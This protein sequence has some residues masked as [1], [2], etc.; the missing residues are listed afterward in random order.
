M[1]D[2]PDQRY[3][4]VRFGRFTVDLN[5]GELQEGERRVAIQGKPLELLIALLERPG[6]LVTREALYARLWPGVTGDYQHGL[7]TAVKKLRRALGDPAERPVYIETLARRGY[8][9]LTP[10]FDLLSAA[11]AVTGSEENAFFPEPG[12]RRADSEAGRLYLQGY[13]CWNKRTPASQNQALAFFLHARELDPANSDYNAAI[14]L[15]HVMRAWHGVERPV[16]AVAEAKSAAVVALLHDRSQVLAC[17]VLAW[18]RGAF[19][20]DL[21]GA[22]S[23]LRTGI[24][25]APDQSWGY[26]QLAIFALA[27]GASEEADE[28]LRKAHE[29][30]PVSPTIFAVRGFV[31]CMSG[32]FEEA[33]E[34]GR[35]AV[36]RDPEFGLAHLYY[37]LELVALLRFDEAARHLAL[38]GQLMGESAEVRAALGMAIALGGDRARAAHID[39]E[40]D[41]AARSRYVDAY[42]RALLK[43]SLGMREA[44]VGLLEQ[45]WED[46]SH[47]CCLAAVDPRLEALR[48]DHRV[49]T[50][51]RRLRR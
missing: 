51:V 4:A 30:D 40:L 43:D 16:D 13:H 50:L 48:S 38:A 34:A 12:L 22:L 3:G 39:E 26:L 36:D 9:L 5:S 29:I 8:R 46:H 45:A 32:R 23:D 25:V 28:A 1:N 31:L 35:E 18:V 2:S 21:K 20:Y 15:T 27:V 49:Q 47:W 19:D 14:A 7:D 44:A 42:H 24:E 10:V 41:E 33:E 6:H 17:F 37:G 11:G